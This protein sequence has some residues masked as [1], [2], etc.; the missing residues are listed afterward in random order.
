MRIGDGGR[1]LTPMEQTR[2][3]YETAPQQEV[4]DGAAPRVAVVDVERLLDGA[5]EVRL[6]FRNEEYRL[7]VTRNRKLILTK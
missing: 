5:R 3:R 7:R 2:D 6:I 4:A 1:T